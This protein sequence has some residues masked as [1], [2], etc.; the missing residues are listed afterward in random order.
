MSEI[1]SKS[2]YVFFVSCLNFLH[3]LVRWNN[4]YQRNFHKQLYGIIY[5]QY[6]NQRIIQYSTC[7]YI[8]RIYLLYILLVPYSNIFIFCIGSCTIILFIFSLFFQNLEYNVLIKRHIRKQQNWILLRVY[9]NYSTVPGI[10]WYGYQY[11]TFVINVIVQVLRYGMV[12][13]NLL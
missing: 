2:F 11:C 13:C 5:F 3:V 10:V 9:L 7:M 1:I 12:R 4:Y 8:Y 6:I